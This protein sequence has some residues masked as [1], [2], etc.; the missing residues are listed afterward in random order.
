M[1]AKKDRAT[2]LILDRSF[3]YAGL[4]M[5]DYSYW[6][7]QRELLEGGAIAHVQKTDDDS[8]KDKKDKTIPKPQKLKEFCFNELDP[9]W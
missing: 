7:T 9:F 2:L 3:D 6:Q 5:H 4:L 1:L 8:K